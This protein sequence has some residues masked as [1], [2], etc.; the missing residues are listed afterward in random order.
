[1]SRFQGNPLQHTLSLRHED[2]IHAITIYHLPSIITTR[3]NQQHTKP[4]FRKTT[5]TLPQHT[6]L[7]ACR[8]ISRLHRLQSAFDFNCRTNLPIRP[9]FRRITSTLTLFSAWRPISRLHPMHSPLTH[10]PNRRIMHVPI[11]SKPLQHIPSLLHEDRFH[12]LTL[13]NLPLISTCRRHLPTGP[14]FRGTTSTHAAPTHTLFFTKT[15]FKSSPSTICDSFRKTC[16]EYIH[17]DF[18]E[19]TSTPPQQTP[20]PQYPSPISPNHPRQYAFGL[21]RHVPLPTPLYDRNMRQKHV[22]TQVGL[23]NTLNWR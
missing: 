23:D 13:C 3:R 11:L 18:R 16:A 4:D 21:T 22:S 8:P 20:S 17:P 10:S 15:N 6:L 12:V 7:P 19:T 9:D 5:S 2:R 1:M 14:G